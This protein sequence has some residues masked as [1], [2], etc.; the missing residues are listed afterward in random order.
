MGVLSI[1]FFF[2]LVLL[3][4]NSQKPPND[5]PRSRVKNSQTDEKSLVAACPKNIVNK[6]SAKKSDKQ[7]VVKNF[8][9]NQPR[10]FKKS[11]QT[12]SPGFSEGSP[13]AKP[14]VK[15]RLQDNRYTQTG[16]KKTPR[17]L[18]KQEEK[19][20]AIEAK[21]EEERIWEDKR[22][23]AKR[24][25]NA[26]NFSV[27]K[28]VEESDKKSA[29][30]EGF[31]VDHNSGSPHSLKTKS[32]DKQ[33]SID[34]IAIQPD[35]TKEEEPTLLKGKQ[36]TCE[37]LKDNG[38]TVNFED[39]SVLELLQFVSKISGTNFVFDSNDLNFNVTIVSH[40]PTSVDDLST[41][42]LQVLKMHDLKVVEQGNNVLIYRN[43]RLSKLSTVV[44]D[45][46]AKDN[47]E[48][49]VVTRVFRLYSVHP[50]SAV[51]II[52]PLLS[53]DAIVSASEATRHVI[54][55]DIAGNVEKVGELLAALDSP[56]TSVDMSE[57][58][59]HYAN[60]ASLVSYC[61]DVLGAMAEDEAFQIFIQPGTNKIFVVSS[62]RLTNKAIQQIGRAHV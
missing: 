54:V 62:P 41:I 1:L 47:C 50:T 33:P 30:E 26:I 15:K 25:V 5:E 36:I 21:S 35:S 14:E 51:N 58:E 28:L 49:V 4:V 59:V 37:D 39:I 12:F 18:P 9:T 55:S 46:S 32:P 48:A 24:A 45:G 40:D 20:E 27:K 23:Y 31:K 19:T 8:P 57:Y 34:K 22:A 3:G 52:Q 43:P 42:L 6:T 60:P 61:Q 56:G 11:T 17:F 16:A 44:T 7:A 2:D 53:H 38:Y 13:F 10:H 29:Q